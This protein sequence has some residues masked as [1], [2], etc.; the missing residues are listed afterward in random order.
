MEL[1]LLATLVAIAAWK[2]K[3]QDQN[4]RIAFLGRHLARYQIEKHMETLTQGYLRALGEADPERREQIWSLLRSTEQALCTQFNQLAADFSRAKEFEARV[5]KLPAYV[6]LATKL[7]PHATFDM[8]QALAIHARGI[9]HAVQGSGD[10]SHRDRAFTVSAE[11]FLMQHTCHWFCKSRLVAS[12]RMLARH[13]TSYE[14]L[15]ACVTPETRAAYRALVGP[16]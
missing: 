8:R 15:I 4:R 13:K 9:S 16:G 12:A 1:F 2:L 11:L 6:P 14:Q 5:S 7:F 3:L 10:A